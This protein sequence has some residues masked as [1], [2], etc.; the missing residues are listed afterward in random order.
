MS[1]NPIPSSNAVSSSGTNT[2]WGYPSTTDLTTITASNTVL[3][4]FY[5]RGYK[6]NNTTGY[7]TGSGFGTVALDWELEIGDEFRFEGNEKDL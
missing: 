4:Q 5:G 1:Q 3:N 7:V 6:M 2:I